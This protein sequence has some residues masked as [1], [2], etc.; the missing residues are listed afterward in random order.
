MDAFAVA[1]C[2]GVT[3]RGASVKQALIVGAWFGAFQAGMPLAGYL[4]GFRFTSY[5]EGY[6]HWIAFALLAVIGGR[7]IAESCRQEAELPDPNPL[8]VMKMLA[9]AVATSI[10][11]L[12]V[13]VSFAFLRVPAFPA[14]GI[15]GI[16]TLA[17]S[18]VGVRLGS[19]FGLR[20]K[21]A[22]ELCGGLML[23]LI[24]GK[25]LFDHLRG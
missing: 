3:L 11:A 25:I 9:L 1:I 14:V 23:I 17:F 18:Y 21:N 13:G 4:A 24:G 10:D 19:L 2:K 8:A 15:I 6:D 16:T 22:A 7:M 5:I 20:Y 12:A